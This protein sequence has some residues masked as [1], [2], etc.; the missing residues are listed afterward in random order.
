MFLCPLFSSMNISIILLETEVLD[1]SLLLPPDDL[2][3][4]CPIYLPTA[5]SLTDPRT[6]SETKPF[7]FC[8]TSCVEDVCTRKSRSISKLS[9]AMIIV[10]IGTSCTLCRNTSCPGTLP[11]LIIFFPFALACYRTPFRHNPS[12]FFLPHQYQ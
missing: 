9:Y 4:P 12:S 2:F 8:R 10:I 5:L 1:L 3:V 7:L 6:A 11:C